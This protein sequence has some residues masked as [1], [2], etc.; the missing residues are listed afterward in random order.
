MKFSDGLWLNRKGYTVHYAT[1][2]YETTHTKNSI[3]VLATA[4]PVFNR[5]MTL[6]GVTFEITY[7]AVADDVIKVNIVH[8]KGAL[9]NK[10]QFELNEPAD[11]TAE[12]VQGEGFIEMT[13]GKTKV[14]IK[15]AFDWEVILL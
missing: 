10:P 14:R 11:Y 8:H 7:T 13:A 3:T 6:G 4:G 1:Q 12:I 9:H 5:A 2:A 15:Q